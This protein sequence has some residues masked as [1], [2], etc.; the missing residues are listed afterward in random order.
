[1]H[2]TVVRSLRKQ[3]RAVLEFIVEAIRAHRTGGA[4]RACCRTPAGLGIAN[5]LSGMNSL[6]TRDTLLGVNA[7][8]ERIEALRE[9]LLKGSGARAE[10]WA[11]S[12]EAPERRRAPMTLDKCLI[13]Y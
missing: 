4:H 3:G 5:S 9:G 1:M 2:V 10:P 6:Y 7:Y 13:A 12:A 8:E 11:R